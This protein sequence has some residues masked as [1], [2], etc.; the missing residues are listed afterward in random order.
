MKIV[1]IENYQMS[2]IGDVLE[3][4]NKPVADLL[5][6]RKIAKRYVAKRKKKANGN[7]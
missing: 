4:V 7:S 3:N 2:M 5:I 6:Q 1:L